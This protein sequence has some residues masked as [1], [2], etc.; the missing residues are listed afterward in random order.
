MTQLLNILPPPAM[1]VPVYSRGDGHRK[2]SICL[3]LQLCGME[4]DLLS[5]QDWGHINTQQ[6][7]LLQVTEPVITDTAGQFRG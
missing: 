4:T 6:R 7:N 2:V 5:G 3:S 1:P